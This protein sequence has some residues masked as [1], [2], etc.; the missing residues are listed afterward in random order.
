LEVLTINDKRT[1]LQQ[2]NE[3]GIRQIGVLGS[4]LVELGYELGS[5]EFIRRKAELKH[6][7][8]SQK[9]CK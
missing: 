2:S 6:S 5:E 8:Q 3:V 9:G 1:L 4:V 7:L